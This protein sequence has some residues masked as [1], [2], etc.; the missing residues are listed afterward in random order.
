MR[1]GL[2]CSPLHHH[3][4]GLSKNGSLRLSL[5]WGTTSADIKKV[6]KALNEFSSI[7]EKVLD[8]S[9]I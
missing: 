2:Q 1:G 7:A 4:L 3:Q 6:I 9:D 5:G 8:V